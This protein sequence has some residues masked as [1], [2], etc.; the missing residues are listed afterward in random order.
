[1]VCSVHTPKHIDW[2]GATGLLQNYLSSTVLG[3]DVNNNN[4]CYNNNYYYYHTIF[5]NN[6]RKII[7]RKIIKKIKTITNK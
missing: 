7:K 3:V 6:K 5:L 4:Y 1:M 2:I